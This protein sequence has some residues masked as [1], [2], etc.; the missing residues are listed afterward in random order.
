MAKIIDELKNQ[1]PWWKERF[2]LEFKDREIYTKIQKFIPLPQIL[3]L[4]GLRRVGKTTLM[5]KIIKDRI[6]NG[7]DPHNILYFSFDEFKGTDIREVIREYETITGKDFNQGTYLLV[8]D[9]IQ[10]LKNWE[11]QIKSIYDQRKPRV[12]I[13]ISGSESLFIRKKS[14]ETLA[15]RIFEF[16]VESLTFKEF[17]YFKEINLRPV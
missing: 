5:L 15:G 13:I 17:L 7:E 11:D 10:K 16:K 2:T 4:S 6:Q 14:K 8:L 9:E 12:K 3:A 1:N